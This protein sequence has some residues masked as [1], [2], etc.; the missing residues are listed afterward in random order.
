MEPDR[1]GRSGDTERAGER[2]LHA[3][4]LGR[5]PSAS[6]DLAVR[7]LEPLITSLRRTFPGVE[8]ALLE[9]AAIDVVLDLAERPEQYDPDRAALPAYLR[10]AA[11]GDVLNA[12]ERERRRA[13]RLAPLEDVELRSPARNTQWADASD[14]IDAVSDALGGE[15]IASLRS[16]FD[17]REWE[18]VQL[19]TEGERRTEV[20]AGLLGLHDRPRAEQACEV[21]RVKDR[22]KKRLQRHWPKVSDS[23]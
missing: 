19:M 12:L 11:K 22:L 2:A 7:Y 21:K 23:D 15:V 20:F 18:V 17:E 3:R 5:D 13:G 4:L 9:T 16:Y 10:M 14:P 1:G 8:A 6:S